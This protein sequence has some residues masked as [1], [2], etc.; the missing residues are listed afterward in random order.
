M[1]GDGDLDAL[2]ANG[3]GQ[4]DILWLNDG[5]ANFTQAQALG[6]S[7]SWD[8][9]LG[10]LDGDGALD[11]L[12]ARGGPPTKVWFNDG[13][14]LFVES[15]QAL[16]T[17]A[18]EGIALGDLDSDGDLDAWF[19]NTVGQAN[20]VWENDGQGTFSD[21]G[22]RL[23]NSST[24]KVALGSLNDE[25]DSSLDAW[26]PNYTGGW[27]NE[28]WLN[29]TKTAQADPICLDGDCSYD[30][31]QSAIDAASPGSL[32]TLPEGVIT[33]DET[34]DTM[35]KALTLEERS[36]NRQEAC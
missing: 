24:L 1:D 15:T 30:S 8:V 36:M 7:T 28:V 26:V 4:S 10:D 6:N 17:G 16:S 2:I 21:T 9:V 32:I 31:I 13:T 3:S 11:A 33:I 29:T 34:I 20:T 14:G 5:G 22:L 35:G 27:A 18:S 25:D 12:V 23:G 19:A